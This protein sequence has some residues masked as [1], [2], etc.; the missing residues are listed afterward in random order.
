MTLAAGTRLGPYEIVGPLGAG[1]MGEVY[2][3]RDTRLDRTV[4][5]KVLAAHLSSQPDLRARFEREARAVS[6]LS[7]PHICVLHDVGQQ[8]GI[9]YLVM[10]YLEGET[11]A[12]RLQRGALPLPQALRHATDIADALDRAH[13]AG[14]VHRDLKPGNVML[15]KSGAKL[16]DFGLAKLKKGPGREPISDLPTATDAK[17]LTGKGSLLGTVLYMA[18]E[19]LEGKEADP[20]TDIFA[21]G[22]VLYEMLTGRRAF[23]A[24]SQASLIAAILEKQPPAITTLLPLT[25]PALERVVQTC[26]AKDPDERWQSAHDVAGELRWIAEGGSQAGAPAVA[27]PPTGWRQRRMRV[28]T[29]ALVASVLAV[30]SFAIGWWSRRPFFVAPAAVT[31]AVLPLT[32][33]TRLAGWASPVLALSPDGR[34]LAFVAQPE[35][36]Q[37][38]YVRRLDR[39]QAE[40]VPDSEGAEGPFFS[41]DGQWL[42]FAVG[43][44]GRGGPR[45]ELKKYSPATGLT[46]VVAGIDDYFGGCWGEDGQITYSARSSDLHRVPASGGRPMSIAATVKRGGQEGM[47]PL[48]WPQPLPGGR[49]LLAIRADTL[50]IGRIVTLDLVTKAF[51]DL[52]IVAGYALYA[53]TGHL[54]YTTPEADLMAVPFDAARQELAGSPSAVL[55]DV[56]LGAGGVPALAIARDGTLVYATGPLRDSGRELSRLVRIGRRGDVEPLPLEPGIYNRVAVSPDG[57][58]VAITTWGAALSIYDVAHDSRLK[59][60]SGAAGGFEFPVWS[61]DGR[62]LAFTAGHVELSADLDLFW[63]PADGSG[64]PEPL[65][66]G[67]GE[68]LPGSFTPDGRTLLYSRGQ[69]IDDWRMGM[70]SPGEK[71]DP[72]WVLPSPEGER[73]PQLS[74]DGAWLAYAALDG[75]KLR[76]FVRPFPGPGR[77]VPATPPGARG[78]LWSANGRELVYRIGDRFFAAPVT[79]SPQ[80]QVSPSRPLFE[81][82]RVRAWDLD[83]TSGAL[84]AVQ[85]VAESGVQTELQLVTGW[86]EELRRLSP[87]REK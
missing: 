48:G 68:D 66:I 32:A 74:P 40:R 70:L 69:G 61:P 64:D 17:P 42:G 43:T 41:P 44:S 3:G 60:P 27:S 53:P 4:A 72:R 6:A 18:P 7:H 26:M 5:V 77:R 51:K 30:T 52:G 45:P 85:R 46:Q 79:A 81:V 14:I 54:L 36:V 25:P 34:T 67:L 33:G 10:E 22:A 23:E 13:R 82:P 29:A 24:Q 84:I 58:R 11:L 86:F 9:D 63:Q 83:R 1:G 38:L 21:L 8:D 37:Q 73:T 55:K 28:A 12:D 15:T 57:G 76:V 50:E 31:R 78:A 56:A 47:L 59:L 75:D 80:L 71:S 62:R 20:R 65:L 16:L 2:K 19:Q 49:A 87:V 39:G 35:G